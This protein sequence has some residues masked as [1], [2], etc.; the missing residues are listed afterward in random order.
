MIPDEQMPLSISDLKN[1]LPTEVL[2]TVA[3]AVEQLAGWLVGGRGPLGGVG[4]ESETFENDVVQGAAKDLVG[5]AN[6]WPATAVREGNWM[7]QV[8]RAHAQAAERHALDTRL[9]LSAL[10]NSA[11]VSADTYDATDRAGHQSFD[12]VAAGLDS[13]SAQASR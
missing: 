11:G 2:E 7:R 3:P 6:G 5:A 1:T 12:P 4:G 10:G 9:S 13:L 8:T